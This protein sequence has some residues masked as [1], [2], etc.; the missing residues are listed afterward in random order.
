MDL[1]TN[2][3]EEFLSKKLSIFYETLGLHLELTG[4]YTMEQNQVAGRINSIVQ[5]MA[6]CILQLKN[7]SNESQV[8]VA[9]TDV[10]MLNVTP[11]ITVQEKIT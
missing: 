6:K 10:N 11:T 1:R 7:L 8:E 2:R 3:G 9:A 4:P 5:E